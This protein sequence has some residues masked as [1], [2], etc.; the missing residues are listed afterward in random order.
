M[1][2]EL[3]FTFTTSESLSEF[4]PAFALAQENMGN[5]L[6]NAQNP[7]L[8]NHYANLGAVQEAVMP[9]LNA[10]GLSVIQAPNGP[11]TLTTRIL[12][13]SGQWV[14]AVSSSPL[15]KQDHQAVGSGITYLRRYALAAMCGITQE[16]DDGEAA[17]R[18]TKPKV[19]KEVFDLPTTIK[20]I[21]TE[22]PTEAKAIANEAILRYKAADDKAAVEQVTAVA[23]KRF[24]KKD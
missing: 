19:K 1:S 9:S 8:K 17:V 14:Q 24:P 20:L 4:A 2:Q 13:K 3:M 12:H 15:G 6:K 10:N 7:H 16:D 18:E 22:P 23:R 11:G 21:E 5:A